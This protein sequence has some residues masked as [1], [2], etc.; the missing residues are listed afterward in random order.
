MIHDIN[1]LLV[2]LKFKGMA[3]VL[4]ELLTKAE[5]NGWSHQE[6][7]LSLFQ[8]ELLYRK[9]RSISNRL[10][11]AKIP[12][13]WTLN[14]FP[15][16]RQPAV[17]QTRIMT[18]AG[19]D[20]LE[21]GENIIFTGSTGTGKSGLASGILRK[22]IISGARGRFYNVQDLLDELYA[23]L[24]DLSTPKLLR[25]LCRYDLL[26]LDELGYL[27]LTSEQMNSFFKLMKERYEAG[28]S[29]IIT[30]NLSFD[31]WYDILKPK[32]MVDALLDRLRHRCCIVHIDGESLRS[33]A[34]D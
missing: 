26:V 28:R 14:S 31:N 9:E 16:D 20:F 32:D 34:T 24:A 12:W 3:A 1:D 27:T 23:S 13:D 21:R 25:Q 4:P 5:R 7:L 2:E 18:L 29:T 22:A 17:D 10:A 11:R 30:T 8:E 15:F 6:L 19:L 33:P